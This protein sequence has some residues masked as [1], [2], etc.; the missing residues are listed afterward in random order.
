MGETGSLMSQRL[1]AAVICTWTH[2]RCL[3]VPDMG[4]TSRR[5]SFLRGFIGLTGVC[6]WF[7]WPAPQCT[8]VCVCV[9]Q[10]FHSVWTSSTVENKLHRPLLKMFFLNTSQMLKQGAKTFVQCNI[11]K[12]KIQALIKPPTL[13]TFCIQKLNDLKRP[14][15]IPRSV[16]LAPIKSR[17]IEP[18]HKLMTWVNAVT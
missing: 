6:G 17:L 15:K 14:L 13:C 2:A 12:K 7:R 11:S 16:L 10:F 1:D 3:S 4:S 18:W 8:C 9:F 5:R